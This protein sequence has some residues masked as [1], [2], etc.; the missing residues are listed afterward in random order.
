[1]CV[2]ASNDPTGV[3]PV[4][5]AGARDA[6][7]GGERPPVGF[8]VQG[9]AGIGLASA[10]AAVDAGA[11]LVATTVY[12]LALTL[13]RVSGESVAESLQG[14]GHAPG[15]DVGKL[16]EAADVIDEWIGD[17]PVAPSRLVSPCGPRSTSS[18][19]GS[20]QRSTRISVRTMRAT[21]CRTCSTSWP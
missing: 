15:L 4:P 10:L 6:D 2:R 7:H 11:D 19:P 16:W 17:E 14:L 1:M 8:Y 20:W 5:C 18:R 13:H 12:P 9:S 21:V 3:R